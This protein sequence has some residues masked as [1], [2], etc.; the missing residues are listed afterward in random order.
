MKLEQQVTSLELSC[1]LKDLGVPQEAVFYWTAYSE[2]MDEPCR[3]SFGLELKQGKGEVAA[4]TCSELGE[5]LPEGYHSWQMTGLNPKH[6]D[7]W[8][9]SEPMATDLETAFSN[10]EADARAKMLVYLIEKGIVKP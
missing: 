6:P 8:A 9:C 5:M 4:F 10:T 2:P 3:G 7:R 1:K